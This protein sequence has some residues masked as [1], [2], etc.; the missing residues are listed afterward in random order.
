[1]RYL[2]P[3]LAILVTGCGSPT[4]P[5]KQE[6]YISGEK[7][8]GVTYLWC[9]STSELVEINELKA[10]AKVVKF[11]YPPA[12]K[13]YSHK[14]NGSQYETVEELI[15]DR[16]WGCAFEKTLYRT[17]GFHNESSPSGMSSQWRTKRSVSTRV[18]TTAKFRNMDGNENG[19]SNCQEYHAL[20]TL[21]S[22]YYSAAQEPAGS[23]YDY[24][25]E[26]LPDTKSY[27][28]Q[29]KLKTDQLDKKRKELAEGEA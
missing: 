20:E 5:W 3:V 27:E 10:E 14:K 24:F 16:V 21:R 8:E 18:W 23:D 26:T 12:I 15:T 6:G 4:E 2:V 28:F 17:T 1:M 13:E 11:I 22:A 19:N 7:P 9:Y 29:L 25:C